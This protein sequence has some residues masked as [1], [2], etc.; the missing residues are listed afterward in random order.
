MLVNAI[1]GCLTRFELFAGFVVGVVKPQY[2]NLHLE[3]AAKQQ[4]LSPQLK[5]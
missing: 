3:T 1:L 5:F 4:G 2:I